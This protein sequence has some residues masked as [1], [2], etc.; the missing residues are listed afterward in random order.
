MVLF[1]FRLRDFAACFWEEGA[2]DWF[3][4]PAFLVKRKQARGQ[5]KKARGKEKKQMKA[6]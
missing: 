6:E 5:E 1:F 2:Q 3:Y 4:I